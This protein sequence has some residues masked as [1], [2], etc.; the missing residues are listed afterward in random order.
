MVL[1]RRGDGDEWANAQQPSGVCVCVSRLRAPLC[2]SLFV[3][4]AAARALYS[5]PP[6]PRPCILSINAGQAATIQQAQTQTHKHRHADTHIS[7]TARVTRAVGRRGRGG[8]YWLRATAAFRCAPV[9]PIEAPLARPR[10]AV[11]WAPGCARV[12]ALHLTPRQSVVST[13]QYS[14]V[15]TVV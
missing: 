13:V 15:D 4:T 8:E 3:D 11:G 2:V 14:T 6:T 12:G 5:T 9:S 7:T 10:L 1:V